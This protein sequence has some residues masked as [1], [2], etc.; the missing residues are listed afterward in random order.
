MGIVISSQRSS[1]VKS[2][3]SPGAGPELAT[4]MLPTSA[5]AC[6]IAMVNASKSRATQSDILQMYD[7]P[8]SPV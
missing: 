3:V 6:H 4:C 8:V 7:A 2:A 1:W 5:C